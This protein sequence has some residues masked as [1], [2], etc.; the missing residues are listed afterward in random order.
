M[1]VKQCAFFKSTVISR[2]FNPNDRKIWPPLST[3]EH[4]HTQKSN[5]SKEWHTTTCS[6]YGSAHTKYEI[7]VSSDTRKVRIHYTETITPMGCCYLECDSTVR[8]ASGEAVEMVLDP[9]VEI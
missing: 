8:E 3:S 4:I 9:E 5:K 1:P 7:T 2:C 6:A